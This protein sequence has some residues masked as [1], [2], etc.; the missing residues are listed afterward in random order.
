MKTKYFLVIGIFILLIGG[1]G[2]IFYNPPEKIDC[3]S[4]GA[5]YLKASELN[6]ASEI[7]DKLSVVVVIPEMEQIIARTEI[8]NCPSF[9]YDRYVEGI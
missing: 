8:L 1:L 7:A 9:D 4:Y 5:I 3:N 2:I 6:K